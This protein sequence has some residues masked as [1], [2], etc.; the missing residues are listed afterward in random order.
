MTTIRTHCR[1]YLRD[2]RSF[3]DHKT[4]HTRTTTPTKPASTKVGAILKIL[5]YFTI[6]IPLAVA[7]VYVATSLCGRVTKK[8]KLT[9]ID[10]TV[11]NK[12][13][14]TLPTNPP[15]SPPKV[16]SPKASL[17]EKLQQFSSLSPL[18]QLNQVLTTY[19][20]HFQPKINQKNLLAYSQSED[21]QRHAK[22]AR[23]YYNGSQLAKGDAQRII[24]QREPTN[25]A[26][27]AGQYNPEELKK[28]F[29]YRQGVFNEPGAIKSD[30]SP[31]STLP[32]TAAVYSETFMWDPKASPD[33]KEIACLSLP[34]P[35]LD[36]TD[37]PHFNYY[38]QNA[39]LD[40]DRYTQEMAFL[41]NLIERAVRDNQNKAF[42]G[43]GIKR[44]VL[45]RFGQAAFLGAMPSSER[46][47]ANHAYR[48][49]LAVFLERIKDTGLPVVMSEYHQPKN[50]ENTWL[51]Q[52]IIGDIVSTSQPGDFIVNAWDPHSAP[53][54]GNDND[55]S[56]DGAM[57]RGSA[58]LLTQTSWLNP[59]LRD[60]SSLVSVS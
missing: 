41:F 53:G 17:L 21:F 9:P 51:D 14:Q 40:K 50:A 49:Q 16:L 43:T 26:M 59:I 55:G 45:C 23:I 30:G 20:P 47:V 5:S 6:V 10:Q 46:Q 1:H 52:M 60:P 28:L 19:S 32:N 22:T 11:Q 34:A 18:A 27:G 48:E 35:A 54:N 33:P 29:G 39:K 13:G 8:K 56:F 4:N 58:I 42:N 2:C 12:A 44:I 38:V 31:Y 7:A 24:F 3:F 36:N 25:I 57:G 15:S 37:Q